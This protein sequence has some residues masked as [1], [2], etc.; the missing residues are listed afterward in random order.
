[1][2]A[3]Q[4]SQPEC[5]VAVIDAKDIRSAACLDEGDAANRAASALRSKLGLDS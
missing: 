4:A 2:V 1:M 5:C 3:E